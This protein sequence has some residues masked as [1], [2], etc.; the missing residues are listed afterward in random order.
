M[1]YRFTSSLLSDLRD[2]CQ[3]ILPTIRNYASPRLINNPAD[4][5]QFLSTASESSGRMTP[6]GSGPEN[7]VSATVARTAAGVRS[8]CLLVRFREIEIGAVVPVMV[9]YPIAQVETGTGLV[10]TLGR[11]IQAH[12]G[13][14][15]FFGSASVGRIGME[16]VAGHVLVEH[17]QAG[18]FL[19]FDLLNFV[20]V[21]GLA[22]RDFLLR[23]RY[24]I[25]VVE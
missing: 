23:E 8:F 11:Q 25:I 12:V 18:H 22:R 1:T 21:V 20:V 5:P 17:A 6:G 10:A 3:T 14:D 2:Q 4:V 15:Q 9:P 24:L 16:N 13:A 19:D 7:L